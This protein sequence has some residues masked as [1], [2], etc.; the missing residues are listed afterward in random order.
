MGRELIQH[1]NLGSGYIHKITNWRFQTT[2]SR[3]DV[4]NQFTALDLDKVCYDMETGKYYLLEDVNISSG[5]PTW[6]EIAE[7][8]G[9]GEANTISSVGGGTSLVKGKVGVDLRVKSL[10]NGSNITFTVGADTI[11]INAVVPTLD[12]ST[13]SRNAGAALAAYRVV[14]EINNTD[15]GYVDPTNYVKTRSYVGLTTAAALSG[16]AVQ[17]KTSGVVINPGWAW[18]PG[19]EVWVAANGT[20]TQVEPV[21][22]YKLSAGMALT[23][24]SINLQLELLQIVGG[25]GGGGA[26]TYG[27]AV[28]PMGSLET[29]EGSL[30]ITGQT[31]ITGT[32]KV[33]ATIGN[34][35]TAKYTSADLRYLGAL[36]VSVT[37]GDYVVG[38]GFTIFIRSVHKIS[39]DISID[40]I[41]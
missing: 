16:A 6:Y 2:A 11:T 40:W 38:T 30:V 19:V 22:G 17:I 39:G 41:Y 21:S 33:I 7:S 14:Y 23:A 10:I 37:V 3:N 31:G 1:G 28:V 5:A 4:L 27:T 12:G 32:T 8:L 20:L 26:V 36:G 25:G 15:V 24:T 13:V 18:V 34:T 35:A 9:V 29:N